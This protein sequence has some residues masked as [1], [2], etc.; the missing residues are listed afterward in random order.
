VETILEH[1]LLEAATVTLGFALA[2]LLRWIAS[3]TAA[4]S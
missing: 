2:Q 3:L 1:L 4:R